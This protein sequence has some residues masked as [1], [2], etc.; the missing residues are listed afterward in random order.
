[1][2]ATELVTLER[3]HE[4]VALITLNRPAALNAL[5]VALREALVQALQTVAQ[6]TSVRAVVLTGAGKGFCAGLD[7]KELGQG[8][9]PPSGPHNDPVMALHA[10]PQPVIGALNGVAI[11][12]G[13]ELA[14][15]CDILIASSQARVADTHARIGI[16]PGWGL[17]QKLSRLIG[18]SRA[19]EMS[20]SGNF[21]DAATAERWGLVNRVVEPEALLPA[22]L[23]LATDIASADGAMLVTYKR[24]IDD[25]HRL[26][27]G[28]ALALERERNRA[29]TARLSA[30]ELAARREQVQARGRQQQGG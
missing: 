18:R 25:G 11:T 16:V 6:D 8:G 1:M 28:E 3:P 2:N 17:S 10:M 9:M 23:A 7:L 12:G 21:V 24:L 19:M 5:S 26:P 22:A 4:G 15:A 30:D 27:L 13:L 29:W 14:L 20:M